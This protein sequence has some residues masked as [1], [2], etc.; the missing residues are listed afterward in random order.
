MAALVALAGGLA[1]AADLPQ[2]ELSKLEGLDSAQWGPAE[3]DGT[4]T[5]RRVKAGR[6]GQWKVPIWWGG[7][8]RPPAGTVYV[9][10]IRYKD[11]P[12]R[13][14]V[15]SAHAGL[16]TYWRLSE[17]H[18]FGGK[19]DGKWKVAEAPVSWDLL[20]RIR[21]ENNTSFSI[22]AE[23]E[24]LPV[25]KVS[26][27]L[28]APGDAEQYFRET[29]E[30]VARL[31]AVRF[32]GLPAVASEKPEIAEALKAQAIVPFVRACTVFLHQHSAPAAGEAGAPIKMRLTREEFRSASFGI[33][34]SGRD[35]KNVTCR[36]SEL[37]GPAGKLECLADLK[38]VEYALVSSKVKGKEERAARK[39]PLR[40]WPAYAVDIPAGR[41]HGFWLTLRTQ[42][43]KSQP[44]I[45]RG[46]VTVQSGDETAGI[47]LEAEVLPLRLLSVDEAG[48]SMGACI[49]A[50]PPEQEMQTFQDYNLRVAQTRFHSTNLPM[51][52]ADGILTLGFSYLD[53]WMEMA[54]SKR[55]ACLRYLLGGDPL[56]YPE[57][58][59]LEKA[60]FT[61]LNNGQSTPQQ[62]IAR[63]QAFREMPETAGV[64]PEI[65]PLY[66][67]WIQ[68]FA[69]H[70]K[71]K[72]W[73]RLV[74]EPFDEPAKWVYPSILPTAS[75]GCLGSGAWTKFHFKDCAKLIHE[76]T[77]D[78]LVG[79][80]IHHAKPGLP[81]LSDVDLVST[82][83]IHED[84]ALGEK[85]RAAG[86]IFW[87]YSGCNAAQPPAIPRYT[88]GFYFGA[89]ESA[90]GV[91]WALNFS[92]RFDLSG[93]D[94][95]AY[96][97]YTPFGT[98]TSPAYEGLREGLDDR[99]LIETCRKQ[100]KGNAKAEGL[101][102]AVLKEAVE[103][104]AKGGTDTVA[105]FY[106]SPTEVLKL[107]AWRNRLLD[108]LC[109]QPNR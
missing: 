28:T 89:F 33:Y 91:T 43:G 48:V 82:N 40:L 104:R 3:A 52:V 58:M 56:G 102:Q 18:R 38:T 84:L 105:D 23:K 66:T 69:S 62:F 55:L 100:F 13:P 36:L 6:T 10:A 73:P 9:L 68:T 80:T 25:G 64:L 103:C 26:V 27:R 83:A 5:F 14:A 31:D 85:V 92:D 1:Q 98:I 93:S 7:S 47:A 95:W 50:L 15:F 101:L 72:N 77:K 51:L 54:K 17:V 59:T 106:N 39:L 20:C 81:F 35:L 46:K 87:Q 30:W 37:T 42:D 86:K 12:S 22:R 94:W 70:A 109:P 76:A 79:A 44:G 96:S 67:Q 45:Y 65:R 41:S 11:V 88:C 29:R 53:E 75:Q 4:E 8:F 107:D 24:E 74:L 32:P 63:H 97:W 21:G 99:R 2:W 57:T 60:L 16:G 49:S 19:A 108:E 90:G 34:A 61:K 71:E 78:A